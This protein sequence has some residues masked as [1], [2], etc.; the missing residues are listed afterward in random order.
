MIECHYVSQEVR[1]RFAGFEKDQDE[2]INVRNGV[3]E[4][5]VPLESSECDKVKVGD[6]VLC[7]Q[8][9]SIFWMSYCEHHDKNSN[10]KCC[11]LKFI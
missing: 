9:I 1:V 11:D 6:L 7:Y 10:K 3:R 5:S 2:W 4:R 8:V